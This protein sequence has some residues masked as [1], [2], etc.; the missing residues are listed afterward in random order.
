[1]KSTVTI[2]F[3]SGREEKYEVEF[4]GGTG[5]QARFQDFIESP[6]VVLQAG[7]ELLVMPSTAI[8]CI[9]IALPADGK[10]HVNLGTVRL[11]KRLK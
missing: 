11:A 8:E 7:G 10:G 9:S 3:I 6:T 5:A 1:M 4:W 2:R